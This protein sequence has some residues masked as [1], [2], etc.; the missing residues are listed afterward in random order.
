MLK[1][2]FHIAFVLLLLCA[3]GSRDAQRMHRLLL[4][5]DAQNKNDSV[6][7]SDSI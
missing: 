6:F 7:R 2:L 4:L 3:C 5:I 1:R